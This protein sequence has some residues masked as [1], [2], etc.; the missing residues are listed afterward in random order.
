M[1]VP[2]RLIRKILAKHQDVE[3]PD[4]DR[5]PR[6]NL[7]VAG[8]E[9]RQLWHQRFGHR[10][11]SALKAT[12]A[13]V[14]GLD[15]RGSQPK[16]CISLGC[17]LGKGHRD[18][19]PSTGHKAEKPL[20]TIHADLFGPTKDVSIDGNILI[21][22]D[23]MSACKFLY[24]LKAKSDAES[25]IRDVLK[26]AKHHDHTIKHLRTDGD[27]VSQYGEAEEAV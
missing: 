5:E 8:K 14:D 24:G 4:N 19:F 23:D 21:I 6:A 10:A 27:N 18:P 2:G 20:E 16:G 12:E 26:I 1:R 25:G 7:A 13:L 3:G 22:S 9:N 15:L 17:Q 11:M